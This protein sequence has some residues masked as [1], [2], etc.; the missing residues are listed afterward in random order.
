MSPSSRRGPDARG[1][2]GDKGPKRQNPEMRP[3]N[4]GGLSIPWL[5]I[6]RAAGRRLTSIPGHAHAEQGEANH[7]CPLAATCNRESRSGYP[8][9]PTERR[10]LCAIPAEPV[11]L[12]S[13]KVAARQRAPRLISGNTTQ[14][15]RVYGRLSLKVGGGTHP[16][17][18]SAGTARG[19]PGGSI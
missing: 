12:G 1:F 14:P 6:R 18:G 17:P 7:S 10:P 19:P 15:A 11:S 2:R 16:R 13:R 3:R 4:P 8:D 9:S 5:Q